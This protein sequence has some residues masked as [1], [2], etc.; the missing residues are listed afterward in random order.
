MTSLKRLT[1]K[2]S[3]V[4]MAIS[5]LFKNDFSSRRDTALLNKGF[6]IPRIQD[7]SFVSPQVSFVEVSLKTFHRHTL[8]IHQRA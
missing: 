7:L 8:T 4:S 3:V 5:T 2:Q 1:F 6:P